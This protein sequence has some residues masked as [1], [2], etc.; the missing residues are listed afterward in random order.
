MICEHYLTVSYLVS[1]R[2]WKSFIITCYN[3]IL[4]LRQSNRFPVMGKYLILLTSRTIR[5]RSSNDELFPSLHC[6]YL[7]EA[8]TKRYYLIESIFC[9]HNFLIQFFI[10]NRATVWLKHFFIIKKISLI[11]LHNC[12]ST[13]SMYG[14][15]FTGWYI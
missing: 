10:N 11:V 3:I 14:Y 12:F 7:F 8:E 5:K 6:L 9:I 15:I 2:P 1:R 13:F 4:R